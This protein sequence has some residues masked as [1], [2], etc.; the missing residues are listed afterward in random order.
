MAINISQKDLG[1]LC[2]CA[3]RYCQDRETYISSLVQGI[4]KAH[5]KEISD[6]DL[7]IMIDDCRFQR[8]MNLYGDEH[9]DKPDWL[10]WEVTLLD[11][12]GRRGNG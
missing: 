2:I 3:I 7:A 8:N 9:I 11:E 10:K 6:N 4:C 5:L 1:T 12:E